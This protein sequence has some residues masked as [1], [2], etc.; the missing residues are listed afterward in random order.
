MPQHPIAFRYEVPTA[1][2]VALI[3]LICEVS[4]LR[5]YDGF[6]GEA[7]MWSIWLL[8]PLWALL[9]GLAFRRRRAAGW[10]AILGSIPML[11]FSSWLILV[12]SSCSSGVCF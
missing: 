6:P 9:V 8:L 12:F 3:A 2:I 1:I 4:W 11:I 7:D 5:G 10:W